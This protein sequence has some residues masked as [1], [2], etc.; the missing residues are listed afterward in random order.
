MP[1]PHSHTWNKFPV[2]FSKVMSCLSLA[3]LFHKYLNCL[4][5]IKRTLDLGK[6]P[7]ETLNWL[8]GNSLPFMLS[9][10]RK[11]W[12][13]ERHEDGRVRPTRPTARELGE[14]TQRGTWNE[15]VHISSLHNKTQGKYQITKTENSHRE[16]RDLPRRGKQ[17][18]LSQEPY[19]P[20]KK[21]HTFSRRTLSLWI[22]L[23]VQEIAWW[24]HYIT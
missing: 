13:V 6:F 20:P 16:Q 8:H 18:P 10:Y 9:G 2:V 5:R 17:A 3:V 24:R 12:W 1:R 21:T 19:P 4:K 23:K 15:G 22:E 14:M 11:V 7:Q